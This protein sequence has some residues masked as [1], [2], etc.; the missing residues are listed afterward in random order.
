M[1]AIEFR[2]GRTAQVVEA[3]AP[4]AGRGD[5]VV[6]V[7]ASG[8]CGSD[9]TALLGTHPF[10]IPPL[11]SGHEAGGTIVEIG[12]DVTGW[13]V[14]DRVAIEPQLACGACAICERGLGHLC[15][16]KVMLGVADW[17]GSFAE[18]VRVPASTLHAVGDAVDDELSALV[19]P[20]AVAV[21]AVR[22]AAETGD[23][24]TAG[25]SEGLGDVVVLGGGTIGAFIAQ[26][27]VTAGARRVAATDP[28]E[29]NRRLCERMGAEA[30]DSSD[31]KWAAEA[32]RRTVHG[33]F[34]VAFVAVAVPG[35]LDRAVSLVHP[36]GTIVQVGLFGAPE[37]FT[38]SALQM[39][40]RRLIGSNVYDADDFRTAIAAIGRDPETV[41]AVITDRGDLAEAAEYL[42]SKA[43]GVADEVVKYIVRPGH[44]ADV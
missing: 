42:T 36:R 16:R 24:R 21:H 18:L 28:R 3:P 32:A 13:T 43:S 37:P 27:S 9:L 25:N 12:P 41:R 8:V 5:V 22:Q 26:Q 23:A 31:P 15:G 35:I 20:M 4:R 39:A 40:E 30:Y 10:R 17:P 34:D 2:T 14:G 19:E 33:A 6:R 44:A 29:R 7:G 1:L 11:I 38:V